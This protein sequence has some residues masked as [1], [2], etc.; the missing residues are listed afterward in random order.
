MSIADFIKTNE[1]LNSMHFGTVY[2]TILI[3]I[4]M[5]LLSVDDLGKI[6]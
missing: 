3:L 1:N 6:R 4:G 5:G 2:Q